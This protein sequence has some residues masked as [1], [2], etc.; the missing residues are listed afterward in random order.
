[1]MEDNKKEKQCTIQNVSS[2][3]SCGK[4]W[5]SNQEYK[6]NSCEVIECG[7]CGGTVTTD[8]VGKNWKAVEILGTH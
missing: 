7:E 6:M 8:Q 2:F 1:M 4:D 5:C 3:C